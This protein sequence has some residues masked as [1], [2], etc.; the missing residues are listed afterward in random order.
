MNADTSTPVLVKMPSG[1]WCQFTNESKARSFVVDVDAMDIY[2]G[3]NDLAKRGFDELKRDYQR[4]VKVN[5]GGVHHD[6]AIAIELWGLLITHA[7]N[8]LGAFEG[9]S[10]GDGQSLGKRASLIYKCQYTGKDG[11]PLK[12]AFESL[13]KQAKIVLLTIKELEEKLPFVDSKTLEHELNKRA[14]ELNTRQNPWRVAKYY[15]ATMI[16][17][18]LLRLQRR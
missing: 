10:R 13:P 15:Q 18:G 5:Y 4:L 16:S 14:G 17:E 3:P 9:K 7:K 11:D 6:T 1:D 8:P 12:A 2:H